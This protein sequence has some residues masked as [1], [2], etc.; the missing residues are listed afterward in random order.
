MELDATTF[1]LEI[2]NFLVLVWLLQRLLYKPVA[3]VIER[4]QAG[5]E[6]TLADARTASSEAEAFKRQFENRLVDWEQE[7]AQARQQLN[8]EMEAE[9]RRQMAELQSSLGEE[10]ARFRARAERQA[11]EEEQRRVAQGR[12]EGGRFVARLL[13]RLAC[14]ELEDRI[15]SLVVADLPRLPASQLQTLREAAREG[16]A[17]VASAYPLDDAQ[18]TRLAA[19]LSSV[20]GR[21][22]AC[23]FVQ[24]AKLVAGLHISIG[25]WV[26]SASLADELKFFVEAHDDGT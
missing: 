7:K 23:R 16:K 11:Q 2:V 15:C 6:K 8:E 20:A 5:I 10:R 18:R 22:V 3:A 19:A 26:L 13:S 21:T 14:P 4:R 1:I 17:G 12:S 24:D 9:R 25:P